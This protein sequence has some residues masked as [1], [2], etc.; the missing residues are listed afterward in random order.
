MTDKQTPIDGEFILG[1]TSLWATL[2][3]EIMNIRGNPISN[4]FIVPINGVEILKLTPEGM[5]Y[6]GK[7]IEDAGEAH[8]AWMQVMGAM[9]YKAPLTD[10]EIKTLAESNLHCDDPHY[11]F[12][13]DG[14]I[15]WLDFARAVLKGRT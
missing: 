10:D 1:P 14:I 15:G 6:K 4:D 8:S 11:T 7:L 13:N 12:G 2:P 3:S 9:G 5:I